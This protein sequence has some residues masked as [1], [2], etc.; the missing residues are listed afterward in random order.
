MSW[1][2]TA[3]IVSFWVPVKDVYGVEPVKFK[4]RKEIKAV[5][6]KEFPSMTVN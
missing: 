3:F 6:S 2:G 5:K 1:I 4:V